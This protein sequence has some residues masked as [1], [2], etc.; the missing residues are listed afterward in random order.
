MDGRAMSLYGGFSSFSVLSIALATRP[1]SFDHLEGVDG[2]ANSQVKVG[3]L[4]GT[5]LTWRGRLS[6]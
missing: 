3:E 2:R 4:F 5:S 6:C 1:V